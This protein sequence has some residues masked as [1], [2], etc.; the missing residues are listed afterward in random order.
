MLT[1]LITTY[2]IFILDIWGVLY[3]GEQLLGGAL[4]FIQKL[5][6]RKR[7]YYLLSNSPRPAVVV[8]KN[9][10]SL[11]LNISLNNILT[12]GQ[13]FLDS[14]KN[15]AFAEHASLSDKAFI[16]GGHKHKELLSAANLVQTEVLH[17]AGY[18]LMLAFADKKAELLEYQTSFK[19]AISYNVPMLCIN[20]DEVVIHNNQKR[21]CQGTF[22]SIYEE[23]G[24]KVVYFGKP[25]KEIYQYL[26]DLHNLEKQGAIMFGDSLSTDIKGAENFGIDSAMLLT[27]IHKNERNVANLLKLSTTVPNYILK[28]LKE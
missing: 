14:L 2:E 17:E 1:K 10:A 27:G 9:L 6:E 4:E 12:S 8:Y 19:E 22:A 15:P 26:F 11:G 21:Y 16:I 5:E 18:L 25:H 23:M 20:P 24:G 3:D 28:D 7:R 13:F